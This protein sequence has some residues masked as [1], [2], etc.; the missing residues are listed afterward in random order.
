MTVRSYLYFPG[1]RINRYQPQYGRATCAV[2]AALGIELAEVELTCCGYP[3]RHENF[4]AALTAAARNLALAA[5]KGMALMTPC[6]CCYGSLKHADHWLRQ[7]ED[8]RL[9]VNGLLQKEGLAWR[10]GIPVRHLLT[11]L[12]EDVGVDIIAAHVHHPLEG[13]K[14]AAHYGCHAL[15]PGHITQF[16]NPLAPTIFERLVAATGATAV[17]WPMRLECCG[18]PLW[19]KDDRLSLALM[20]EKLSD[21]KLAGGQVITTACTYC[22]TQFDTVQHECPSK[23]NKPLP[24]VLYPQLLGLAMGMP[25]NELGLSDNRIPWIPGAPGLPFGPGG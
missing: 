1:C 8:L 3:V 24:A 21:A 17:A 16:D 9:R 20:R 13:L 18:H 23:Q 5:E 15:R 19:Q 7:R 10:P 25:P 2:M 4:L 22:Q 14:V 6:Q 12:L 11:V